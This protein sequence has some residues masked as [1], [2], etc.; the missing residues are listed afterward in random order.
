MDLNTLNDSELLAE[1][2]SAAWLVRTNKLAP[3]HGLI[4]VDRRRVYAGLA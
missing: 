4:E 1:T 2:R 3:F